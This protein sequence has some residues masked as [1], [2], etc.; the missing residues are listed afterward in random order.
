MSDDDK[1][2]PEGV[3]PLSNPGSP[4]KIPRRSLVARLRNY[5][6]AGIIVTAPI[7]ITLW[8]S[9][10]FIT[11]VDSQVRPLIPERYNPE[12][13]LPIDL[14]GLGLVVMLVVLTAI[15]ALAAGFV[16]RAVVNT[17]ERILAGM[18]VVRS[19]Y[20]ALKQVFETVFAEK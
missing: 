5:L 18:P 15:G 3:V 16:G 7:F 1:T 11:Y 9:W 6:L 12:T 8:V 4:R 19:V 10:Q 20:A 2:N 17:G 13:Y 14:P